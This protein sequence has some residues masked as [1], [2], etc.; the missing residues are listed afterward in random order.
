M[1]A[2]SANEVSSR[3]LVVRSLL[4]APANRRDLILKFPRIGADCSVI[5][6]EDGTP[7]AITD[8]P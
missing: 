3:S 5:D 4:F 6:L 8:C 2:L 1:Q 7:L